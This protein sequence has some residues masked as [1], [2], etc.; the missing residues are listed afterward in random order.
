MTA[1]VILVVA[2]LVA[3]APMVPLALMWPWLRDKW[4]QRHD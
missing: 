4:M 3:H 2:L 1:A